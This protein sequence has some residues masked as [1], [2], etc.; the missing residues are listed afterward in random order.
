LVENRDVRMA[1]RRWKKVW[2][3]V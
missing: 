1:T 2:W 3:Y